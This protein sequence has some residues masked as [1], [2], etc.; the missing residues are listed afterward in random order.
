MR[1]TGVFP[2]LRGLILSPPLRKPLP[3]RNTPPYYVHPLLF[4]R[5]SEWKYVVDKG[6][7][8]SILDRHREAQPGVFYSLSPE[9]GSMNIHV[10]EIINYIKDHPHWG[11][12]LQTHK[13]IG[14]D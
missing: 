4:E 7:D 11:L 3:R 12:S 13:W 1:P 9:Y 10:K 8:F 2:H 5:T 6:F 14:I